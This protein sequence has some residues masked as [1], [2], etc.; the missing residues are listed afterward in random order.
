MPPLLFAK[1]VSKYCNNQEKIVEEQYNK[2]NIL[3]EDADVDLTN[4]S[5]IE[6]AK[7]NHM[8]TIND[9]PKSHH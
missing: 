6:D 4:N 3:L 5:E 2:T 8:A 7:P 9:A 1:A